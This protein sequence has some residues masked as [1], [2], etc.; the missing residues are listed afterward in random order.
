MNPD[1]LDACSVPE[2]QDMH[3]LAMDAVALWL[4]G[5]YTDL[6]MVIQS[7]LVNSE[8]LSWAECLVDLAHSV[9]V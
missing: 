4:K 6:Q 7:S 2:P 9:G 1:I 3:P 5:A 8:N